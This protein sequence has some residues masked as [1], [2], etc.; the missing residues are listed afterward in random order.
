MFA[1]GDQPSTSYAPDFDR[2]SNSVEVLVGALR[3]KLG[4][5]VIRTQSRLRLLHRPRRAKLTR[6][7]LSLRLRLIAGRRNLGSWRCWSLRVVAI[8]LFLRW[9]ASSNRAFRLES[10]LDRLSAVIDPACAVARVDLPAAGPALRYALWRALLAGNRRRWRRHRAYALA[11]DFALPLTAARSLPRASRPMRSFRDRSGQTLTML[12]RRIRLTRRE[13]VVSVAM[14]PRTA[15]RLAA[16][17]SQFSN[18]TGDRLP[19]SIHRRSSPSS[20]PPPGSS[21]P[22]PRRSRHRI[23]AGIAAR[24][25][26]QSDRTRGR[27]TRREAPPLDRARVRSVSH[28]PSG[29]CSGFARRTPHAD[30]ATV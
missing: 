19:S 10:T 17:I 30:L 3:K 27:V 26:R 12:A 18:Q 16:T 4:T 14:V 8:A 24:A 5:D 6:F 21:D 22:R 9:P 23:R 29:V 1:D 15:A 28:V 2:D 13:Q 11:W 25:E 7:A 20:S